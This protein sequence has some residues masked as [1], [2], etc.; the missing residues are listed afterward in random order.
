MNQ[1]GSIKRILG[2]WTADMKT[3]PK[4]DPELKKSKLGFLF[5]LNIGNLKVTF[6]QETLSIDGH[7]SSPIKT[8]T[9][10]VVAD[11]GQRIHLAVT[12]GDR[13]GLY[14]VEIIDDTH[15]ILR[16]KRPKKEIMALKRVKPT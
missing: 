5:F 6:T 1:T 7:G 14:V 15:I 10:K 9:Y 12:R 8:M 16:L 2:T 4:V 3:W 11:D 13:E